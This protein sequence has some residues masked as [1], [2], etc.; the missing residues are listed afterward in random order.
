VL[1]EQAQLRGVA[2]GL[3]EISER[4]MGLEAAVRE[5]APEG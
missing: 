2:T 5:A 4:L 3:D 1:H